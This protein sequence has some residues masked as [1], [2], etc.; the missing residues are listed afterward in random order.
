MGNR[1]MKK[2]RTLLIYLFFLAIL[3]GSTCPANDCWSYE[4]VDHSIY[5]DLLKNHVKDGMVDYKGFKNDEAKLDQ[6]LKVLENIDTKALSR[7]EQF[8]F[9]INAYNAWTLK[10]ILDG[11]PGLK[12]I[13]DLGGVF[14]SP[15]KKEICRLD[16]NIFS[17]DHIEHNILRPRY[18]DPR[19]HFGVNCASKSCPP[20]LAKPYVG[21]TLDK[22]LEDSAVG[23]INNPSYN[24]FK[25]NTL[26]VSKIFEWFGGDFNNNIIGY[27]RK[28]ARGDLKKALNKNDSK[29]KVKYL[30]YDWS[31]NGE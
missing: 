21:T 24:Y 12:S 3:S 28:Y 6:Y 27:V 13:K 10:L 23:F 9:Y 16:G 26:Y 25:G 15:W 14:K 30:N 2:L 11:Y 18:K 31:L 7:N 17:L 4:T 1:N 8:A 5:A 29:I 19:V 20:L 22:Q